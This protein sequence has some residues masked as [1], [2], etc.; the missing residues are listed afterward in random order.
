MLE[1][2]SDII[3]ATGVS[4]MIS[5]AL[6][7]GLHLLGCEKMP[8][9]SEWRPLVGPG[10]PVG[11]KWCPLTQ[12]T[13]TGQLVPALAAAVEAIATKGPWAYEDVLRGLEGL[14]IYVANR[15]TWHGAEVGKWR[16]LV[17]RSHITVGPV[18]VSLCHE[19]IH[20]LEVRLG[21]ELDEDHK[22]WFDGGFHAADAEYNRRRMLEFRPADEPIPAP[23][24]ILAQPL[25]L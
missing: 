9:P 5:C 16:H 15:D 8:A 7:V 19:L 25:K 1:L 6:V 24:G 11:V 3:V 18:L 14:R 21:P 22:L 10:I 23:R 2:C 13:D 12:C 4:S 17:Q 20:V